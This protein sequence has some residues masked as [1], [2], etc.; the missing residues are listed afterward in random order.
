MPE[1]NPTQNILSRSVEIKGTLKFQN[2]LILDGKI[3]GEISSADG[4]L[5]VGQNAEVRG[6]INTK[7][8]VIF[9]RVF[10]NVTVEERCELKANSELIGDLKSPRLMMEEGS[11]FNGNSEVTPNKVNM[12]KPEIVRQ[13][14][15]PAGDHSVKRAHRAP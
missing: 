8:V 5:T 11:T 15:A 1:I 7:S 6:D 4:F 9:G 12:W 10:G 3:D 14:A 13:P 2:E